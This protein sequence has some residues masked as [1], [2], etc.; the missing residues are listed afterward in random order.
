[1]DRVR[2]VFSYFGIVSIFI[3]S[4]VLVGCSKKIAP[5]EGASGIAP[6]RPS[7]ELARRPPVAPEAEGGLEDSIGEEAVPPAEGFS[8]F[9]EPAPGRESTDFEEPASDREGAG[10]EPFILAERV[11]PPETLPFSEGG[12]GD[13]DVGEGGEGIGPLQEAFFEFD[14]WVLKDDAKAALEHNA[15]WLE[16]H[17]EARIQIEG[18]CDVRG[19]H[20]YNLALG[21]RR[22]KSAMNFLVSMGVDRSRISFI[23]FGEEK[24]TCSEKN[25]VC[26]KKNR[27]AYFVVLEK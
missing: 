5:I 21:E 16:T 24:N 17:P 15:R 8:F 26:Y 7:E 14:Q 11:P 1:M 25:E 18:H 20:E 19:T 13:I 10:E 23:S 22:A 27:R 2:G 12:K 3:S 6:D 4:L 9:E